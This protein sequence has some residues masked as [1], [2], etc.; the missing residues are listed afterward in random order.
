MDT[1][2]ARDLVT[3]IE[4]EEEEGLGRWMDP[5]HIATDCF[6]S[7]AAAQIS[8]DPQLAADGS[9]ACVEVWLTD[10]VPGTERF[11]GIF[12]VD[13]AGIW[14]YDGDGD[15]D[16]PIWRQYLLPWRCVRAMC[17]HQTS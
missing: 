17:I 10:Y 3:G 7:G 5:L 14:Y 4:H 8:R 2:G 1:R 12:A 9:I 13:D 16:G 6:R 15:I 11:C